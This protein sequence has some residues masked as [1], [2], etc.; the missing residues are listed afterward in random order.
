MSLRP[1]ALIIILS[2]LCG[3]QAIAGEFNLSPVVF[4]E[5]AEEDYTLNMLGPI[6]AFSSKSAALRPVFYR[7]DQRTD[8]LFPLGHSTN[9]RGF[10]FPI[11]SCVQEDNHS[12]RTLFPLFYGTYRD[13]SYGGLFPL[14]GTLYHRF[15]YDSALFVLWPIYSTTTLQDTS[16]YYILWPVFS[17]S[18]D[19]EFK[20][21]PLY[22]YEK[23]IGSR[24]DF[25][26]W[27]ILHRK[28][29]IEN[30]DAVLPLFLYSRGEYYKNISIIWPFFSYSRDFRANHS[31]IDCPW[32]LIRFA[33]GAY[34]QTRIFPF[35]HKKIIPPTYSLTSILWPLYRKELNFDKNSNLRREKTSILLLSRFSHEIS[36]QGEE[37]YEKTLWPVWHHKRTAYDS[38]WHVPWILPFRQEGY[39]RNWLPVLTLAHAEKS[40]ESSVVDILWHT[41]FYK[42][43]ETTSRLSL[44]FLCSYEK[45]MDYREFAFFFDLLKIRTPREAL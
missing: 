29:G 42:K 25:A 3:H 22:G 40:R 32:P 20:I 13:T 16:S 27:P 39:R 44:S 28:R 38:T 15:G 21:F 34:E 17:Y 11:Y 5:S 30:M 10:F 41:I 23:S 43:S 18:Q 6:L 8:I 1:I 9:N 14:Y 35:Y 19:S 45:G 4:Y 24:H 37:T 7:D 31:S 2:I 36:L 26:L 33:K 12:R